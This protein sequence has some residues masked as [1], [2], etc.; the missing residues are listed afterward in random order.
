VPAADRAEETSWSCGVLDLR[1]AIVVGPLG[2]LDH[3]RPRFLL[4]FVD[5]TPVVTAY[6]AITAA[7]A[8]V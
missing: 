7:D 2:A 8:H 6:E 5:A 3:R 4:C 1:V